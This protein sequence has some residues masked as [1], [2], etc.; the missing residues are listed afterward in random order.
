[1]I[2]TMTNKVKPDKLSI[3]N[4]MAQL[5]Q[6]NRGFYDELDDSER[7]K[8][9]SFL[10]LKWGSAVYGVEEMQA[11][12]L[13]AMNEN[14]NPYFFDLGKH[15]KLQW[16]LCTTVSPGLGI[17]KHWYPGSTGKKKNALLK[18]LTTLRPQDKI[19]DLELLIQL[20]DKRHFEDMA[21]KYGW[22]NEEIKKFFS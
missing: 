10:M 19:E 22:S 2:L 12:Y 16:L 18:F 6:K 7:K 9:S 11:Y 17:Q 5:D 15:P 13:R 20:N 14:V 8:F 4:E 21:R 1:M 3:G